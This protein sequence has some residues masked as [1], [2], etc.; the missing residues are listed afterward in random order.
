M[1]I[2]AVSNKYILD[3]HELVNIYNNKLFHVKPDLDY[4]R[5]VINPLCHMLLFL[6]LLKPS[7]ISAHY[8]DNNIYNMALVFIKRN[9][10]KSISL[11]DVADFCSCSVS[12]VCHLFRKYNGMTVKEYIVCM[13]MQ[14]AENL[15]RNS[16]LSISCIAELSGFTDSDYFSTVFKKRH[17]LTP[18]K[19]RQS[20]N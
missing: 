12:S 13:R 18:T 8:N 14:N 9:F 4:L 19:F 10:A 3:K 2:N 20:Y 7:E 16:R 5:R 6:H 1:R 15:L 11:S 17:G